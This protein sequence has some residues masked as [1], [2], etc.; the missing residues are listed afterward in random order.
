VTVSGLAAMNRPARLRSHLAL[1]R[2][3]AVTRDELI[4]AITHLPFYG[5]WPS[6][7]VAVGVARE[8][9]QNR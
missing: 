8:V 2:E 3:N 1:A 7:V 9:L 6:A 4:E 5:G